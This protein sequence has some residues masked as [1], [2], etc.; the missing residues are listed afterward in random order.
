MAHVL[1][2][3]RLLAAAFASSL[4]GSGSA[5]PVNADLSGWVWIEHNA[6]TIDALVEGDGHPA[7]VVLP[8][9]E[10]VQSITSFVQ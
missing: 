8:G 1:G 2:S 10:G 3:S 7:V 9:V 6:K 5:Q 4:A